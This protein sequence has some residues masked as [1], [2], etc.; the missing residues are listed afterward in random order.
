MRHT[1]LWALALAA[2]GQTA[3][4]RTSSTAPDAGSD[5]AASAHP[6][7]AAEPAEPSATDPA[8]VVLAYL[9]ASARSDLDAAAALVADDSVVFESGGG[10]GTWAQYREHHL[11]PEVAMFK[12]FD[13]ETQTPRT[14][15]SDDGSLALVTLPISYDIELKDGRKISSLGTVTFGLTRG[16]DGPYKIVHMHWSSRRKPAPGD[17][18]HGHGH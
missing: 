10:Q 2:C 14:W 17:G 11:G 13:L 5:M 4:D 9:D 18:G 16:G 7:A 1:L 3:A 12:S 6:T 8:A 15:T